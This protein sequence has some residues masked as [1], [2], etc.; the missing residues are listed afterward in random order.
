VITG[1]DFAIAVVAL[2]ANPKKVMAIWLAKAVSWIRLK[3]MKVKH[4]GY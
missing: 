1:D 4:N 2:P 3:M